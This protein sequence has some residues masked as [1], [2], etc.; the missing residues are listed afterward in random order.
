L[1]SRHAY[2][3]ALSLGAQASPSAPAPAMQARAALRRKRKEAEEKLAQ[4]TREK[5]LAAAAA[6]RSALAAEAAAAAA[7]PPKAS[8]TCVAIAPSCRTSACAPRIPSVQVVRMPPSPPP[9][10]QPTPRTC[11][12]YLS[13]GSAACSVPNVRGAAP[14]ACCPFF[15][16][17]RLCVVCRGVCSPAVPAPVPA[18][19]AACGTR[20]APPLR[21]HSCSGARRRRRGDGGAGPRRRRRQRP[22]GLPEPL[23]L[24]EHHP[25]CHGAV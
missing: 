5:V 6:R 25:W 3:P 16:P 11:S 18:G 10:P 15:L 22:G 13:A 1:R 9:H 14:T 8:R 24:L 7:G 23:R 17:C 2:R 21:R 19:G 12:S 20:G 4:E